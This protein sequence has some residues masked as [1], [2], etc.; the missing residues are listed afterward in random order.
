VPQFFEFIRAAAMAFGRWMRQAPYL[1][2]CGDLASSPHAAQ[3]AELPSE[4]QYAAVELFRGTMLRHS[5]VVYR[6]DYPKID[7]PIQFDKDGWQSYIP[8]RLPRTILVEEKLPPGAAAVLINQNHTYTDI[9]LPIDDSERRV[10][11][12]IDGV[13]SID[14]ILRQS[15][16]GK[17]DR[18]RDYFKKLWWYDQVS[19][20]TSKRIGG[21]Q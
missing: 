3:L 4:E 9:Y 19:F 8:H 18:F 14:E 1:P 20:D 11:E 12:A 15:I 2:Y 7:D 21:R 10:F 16:P 6:E 17:G 13:R 5:A